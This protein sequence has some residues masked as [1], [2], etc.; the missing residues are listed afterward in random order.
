[1]ANTVR[2]YVGARYVPKFADPVAWQSGT[3]YEA[4][5]IVTY[6][7][8]SYT[9]KIPVPATVGNPADNDTYW[10]LTGNYNA[11]VEAYREETVAVQED[12]QQEISD[13]ETADNTLQSN[14]Y[15]TNE[16]V[17]NNTNTL[18][19]LDLIRSPMYNPTIK[20]LTKV[21]NFPSNV[22]SWQGCCVDNNGYIYM[23]GTFEGAESTHMLMKFNPM[24]T[25][26]ETLTMIGYV[27]VTNNTHL[28]ALQ[29]AGGKIY[30]CDGGSTG[31]NNKIAVVNASTM[32]EEDPIT[33]GYPIVSIG[34]KTFYTGETPFMRIF[35]RCHNFNCLYFEDFNFD[36][37]TNTVGASTGLTSF[38]NMPQTVAFIQ[39][40]GVYGNW[41]YQAC[42]RLNNRTVYDENMEQSYILIFDPTKAEA[43]SCVSLPY[44]DSIYN[45]IESVFVWNNYVYVTTLQGIFR[46]FP[47]IY[48]PEISWHGGSTVVQTKAP[49]TIDFDT[50][51]TYTL[52]S[53]L[54]QIYRNNG[55][56]IGELHIIFNNDSVDP[57]ILTCISIGDGSSFKQPLVFHGVK[58]FGGYAMS[59]ACNGYFDTENNNITIQHIGGTVTDENNETKRVESFTDILS[60]TSN[61]LNHTGTTLIMKFIP[62]QL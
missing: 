62:R 6:N 50:T 23:G 12:L 56:F 17:T 29:Y 59:L 45:E 10:A 47:N 4:L 38:I 39:G 21:A 18:D 20:E 27:N 58:N 28:N 25:E 55:I 61:T 8:S 37:S 30:I 52:T 14:I 49:I 43:Y 54:E 13:R 60:A 40:S 24:Q 33:I 22:T 26:G 7:N 31:T 32:V 19:K 36:T 57:T 3:S 44:S 34:L 2:Q 9:S 5:T 1:M 51:F 48:T 53:T 15:K 41:Y 42:S 11:Q 35:G 16:S 46:A